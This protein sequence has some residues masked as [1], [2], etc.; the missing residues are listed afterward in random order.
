MAHSLVTN[1]VDSAE[2]QSESALGQRRAAYAELITLHE[3]FLLR[4]AWRFCPG[5]HDY[6]QDLV[7]ETLVHGYEAFLKG[8]FQEG[9]NARAWLLTILTNCFLTDHR[10]LRRIANV[11]VETVI[12]AGAQG[13]EA[14]QAPRTEQPESA[15][16]ARVLDEPLE[17]ALAALSDDLRLCV[18]L[19]DMEELSY[20]EAASVLSIP[21][22]TVRSRLFRARR[23]LF[24]HL[25]E[26]AQEYRRI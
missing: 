5:Q 24:T 4:V 10:R 16:L 25:Q 6:A 14:L 22:G 19:V 9:T 13:N 2:A 12:A 1:G 17:Q 11:D 8:R 7:Q 23:Q 18:V 20:V 26:Y 3:A 21:V 15:L